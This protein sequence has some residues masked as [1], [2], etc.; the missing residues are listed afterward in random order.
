[1][2]SYTILSFSRVIDYRR[3]VVE[4]GV[5]IGVRGGVLEVILRGGG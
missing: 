3:V 1:M 4:I 2:S 5:V